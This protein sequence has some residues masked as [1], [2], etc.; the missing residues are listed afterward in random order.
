MNCAPIRVCPKRHKQVYLQAEDE[1]IT[2]GNLPI[3]DDTAVVKLSSISYRVALDADW[4][5]MD[6]D[7]MVN[8]ED[9]PMVRGLLLFFF[10]RHRQAHGHV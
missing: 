5:G 3:K 9:C 2:R 10:F 8:N 1:V 7:A 6:A 4:E